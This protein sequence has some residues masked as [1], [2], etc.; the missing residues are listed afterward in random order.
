M[1]NRLLKIIKIGKKEYMENL[2]N[3]GELYL[4]TAKYYRKHENE[5]IGDSH[6]NDF[7]IRHGK[8]SIKI[9]DEYIYL[10]NKH[11]PI[12]FSNPN[13][14]KNLYCTYGVFTGNFVK[15]EHYMLHEIPN[16]LIKEF[17][18]TIVCIINPI[19]FFKRI[20]VAVKEKGLETQIGHVEY[21]NEDTYD[22]DLTIFNKR[23]QFSHQNEVRIAINNEND[24][25]IKLNIGSI[26]DIA[27]ILDN[28]MLK[29][30]FENGEKYII[31]PIYN[32]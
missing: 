25:P 13:D 11:R 20:E 12:A 32:K 1:K 8:I 16:Y 7:L 9:N 24:A 4:N 17:G 15:K 27:L 23:K 28:K 14:N 30:E 19:E 2:L 5:Q 31:N 6:E 10:Y 21:Y 18:G 26:N 3:K 29:H 22:G